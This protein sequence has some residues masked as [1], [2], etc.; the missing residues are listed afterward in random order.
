MSLMKCPKCGEMFSDSYKTCPFCEE[1]E[2]YYGGKVKKHRGRRTE[3]S[4][5]HRAPS[6][7]GPVAVLVL[8]LLAALVVW[9]IFGDQIKEVIGGDRTQQEQV[10]KPDNSGSIDKPDENVTPTI[11]LNRTVLAL[12]VGGQESLTV[13]GTEDTVAWESSDPAVASVNVDGQVTAVAKG[14]AVITAR[15][16]DEAVTCTVT[17][18]DESDTQTSGDKTDTTTKVDVSTWVITATSEYG[19]TGELAATGETGVF[20][21]S[22]NKGELWTLAIKGASG[23]PTWEVE[24]NTSGLITLDGDKLTISGSSGKATVTGTVNGGTVTAVIRLQ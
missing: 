6:I 23:T 8:L 14:T 21:M 2:A 3:Q 9:L 5:K 16:G 22:V 1:D 11:S 24:S 7:L 12:T 15:V 20:E 13:S 19:Y 4:R 17:V 10:Q 18:A